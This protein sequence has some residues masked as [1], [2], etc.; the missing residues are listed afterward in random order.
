MFPVLTYLLRLVEL[1]HTF[2]FS[3][4]GREHCKEEE[5]WRR[6]RSGKWK[7]SKTE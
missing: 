4:R 5:N 6:R 7:S 3:D 1:G 2:L